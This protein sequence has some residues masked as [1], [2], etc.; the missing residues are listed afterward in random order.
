M[1]NQ[2][3]IISIR[4]PKGTRSRYH[5]NRS[6]PK[7]GKGDAS[8]GS[9]TR[10]LEPLPGL[11]PLDGEEA[12]GDKSASSLHAHLLLASHTSYGPFQLEAS[13]QDSWDPPTSIN[14]LS[15]DKIGTG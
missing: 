14:L 5:V 13:K 10:R 4:R 7:V 15:P 9:G 3:E 8:C 1:S 12:K 11:T 2:E 6:P